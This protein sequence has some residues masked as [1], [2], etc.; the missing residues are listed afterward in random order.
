MLGTDDRCQVCDSRAPC[1][2]QKQAFE[3]DDLVVGT[4]PLDDAT[5]VSSDPCTCTATDW[6]SYCTERFARH[7][8]EPVAR[9]QAAADM[10]AVPP[11]VVDQLR[12]AKSIGREL[13]DMIVGADKRLDAIIDF[14]KKGA[15]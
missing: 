2:C 8:F 4:G 6:C 10:E 5:G 13:D 1:S 7:G 9:E 12:E 3:F 15:A 14:F 11:G